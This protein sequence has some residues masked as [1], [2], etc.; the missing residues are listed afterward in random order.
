MN[1]ASE[2]IV[3]FPLRRNHAHVRFAKTAQLYIVPRHNVKNRSE[4][5][6][7]DAEYNAMKRNIKRDVLQVQVRA[8]ANDLL[9]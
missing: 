9:K 7:T 3:D 2:L 5:W 1:M 6:Y 8:R 4:L